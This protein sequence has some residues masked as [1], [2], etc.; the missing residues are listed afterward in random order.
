MY[1]NNQRQQ[2]SSGEDKPKKPTMDAKLY[3]KE[4]IRTKSVQISTKVEEMKE[5][6]NKV[7]EANKCDKYVRRK[8]IN[9]LKRDL[10]YE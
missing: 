1:G 6:I 8:T 2:Q 5:K 10:K 4:K 9:A 7:F 3:S